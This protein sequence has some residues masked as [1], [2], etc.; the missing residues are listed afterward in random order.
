MT[1][2]AVDSLTPTFECVPH[3][4]PEDTWITGFLSDYRNVSRRWLPGSYHPFFN[5]DLPRAGGKDYS[6]E[7]LNH[8]LSQFYNINQTQNISKKQFN[9]Y[10][11]FFASTEWFEE[12]ITTRSLHINGIHKYFNANELRS[13]WR[14]GI[15]IEQLYIDN[16]L[17]ATYKLDSSLL[18]LIHLHAEHVLRSIHLTKNKKGEW[19]R[20]K[21]VI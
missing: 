11:S 6:R 19:D 9:H 17:H 8:L 4:Q 1:R 16:I 2:V 3:F 18:R 20:I 15:T 13:L 14:R 12:Q 21:G 10:P 7:I 5:W